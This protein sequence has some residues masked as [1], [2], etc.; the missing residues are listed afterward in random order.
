MN[1]IFLDFEGVLVSY[2]ELKDNKDL[3]YDKIEKRI[4]LLGQICGEYNCKVVLEASQKSFIDEETMA[5]DPEAEWMQKIFDLFLK[6]GIECIG[7]TPSVERKTGK[8]TMLPMWKE[9]EIRLYLLRHPEIEHYCVIDDDDTISMLH[10]PV[11]DLEKV[12]GHLVKTEY[13]SDTNPEETCL[14]P[15]HK[16]LVGQALEKENEISRLVHR[17]GYKFGK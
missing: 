10:W 11:S 13:Y 8:Y 2:H 14:L 5:I 3:P 16:E 7:R 15:E 4:E 12:R 9:D 6:H 1:V 17:W